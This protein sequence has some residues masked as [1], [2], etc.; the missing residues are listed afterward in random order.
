[1]KGYGVIF[2]NCFIVLYEKYIKYVQIYELWRV[3]IKNKYFFMQ[4]L[5]VCGKIINRLQIWKENF[6]M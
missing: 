2:K 1:M 6:F 4:M 3:S 5:Y